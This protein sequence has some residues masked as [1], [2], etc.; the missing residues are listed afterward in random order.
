MKQFMYINCRKCYETKPPGLSMR[1]YARNEICR[2]VDYILIRCV[3]HDEDIVKIRCEEL[4]EGCKC[5]KCNK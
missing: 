3:R 4:K 5:Q 2:G 1:E